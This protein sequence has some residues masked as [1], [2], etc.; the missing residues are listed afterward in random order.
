MM[1]LGAVLAAAGVI[2]MMVAAVPTTADGSGA[3]SWTAFAVQS[4][5]PS[6]EPIF[7]YVYG[8][9]SGTFS[10]AINEQPF[11]A[12]P[13]VSDLT[14]QLPNETN[15][16]GYA[17]L[18]VSI[19]TTMLDYGGLQVTISNA[20]VGPFEFIP[21]L[22]T[23][24]V[25]TTTLYKMVESLTFNYTILKDRQTS[26]QDH[27]GQE[28]QDYF[29]NNITTVVGVVL[30][31]LALIITRSRASERQFAT[32]IRAWGHRNTHE[33]VGAH[34]GDLTEKRVSLPDP[35]KIWFCPM[36]PSCTTCRTPQYKDALIAHLTATVNDDGSP[37]HQVRDPSE[38]YFLSKHRPTVREV[39]ARSAGIE[40]DAGLLASK[41][42][43]LPPDLL[44]DLGGK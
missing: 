15:S 16:T 20:T 35:D 5:V 33:T 6:G 4:D 11:N 27:Q 19:P 7:L 28:D 31:F 34:F 40:P 24:P 22:I 1:R 23:E 14:Y 44:S 25:N 10:V 36:F 26:L 2:L 17:E 42:S 30:I 38:P 8:P 18:N 13:P 41:I 21:M 43:K 9:A 12:T 37:G 32:R 29:F 3:V 39:A